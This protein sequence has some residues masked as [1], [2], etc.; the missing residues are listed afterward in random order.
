MYHALAVEC[1]TMVT[2]SYH[3]IALKQMNNSLSNEFVQYYGKSSCNSIAV[4]NF[5]AIL[6]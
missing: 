6:L 4:S 5:S 1:N 3:S 2:K